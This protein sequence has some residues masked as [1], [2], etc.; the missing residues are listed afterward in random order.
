[1]KG[2]R[3]LFIFMELFF[4]VFQLNAQVLKDNELVIIGGQKF[5]IHQVRTGET[6]YSLSRDFRTE[7]SDIIQFNEG[8]EHGINIGALL[9]IPYN[10][11]F[12]LSEIRSYKK[13]DP[14]A[15]GSYTIESNNETAYSV[16]KKFG[17]SVEEVYAYNPEI[18]RLKKGLTIRIPQWEFKEV[19]TE[20]TS[21][22][23]ETEGVAQKVGMI[24][25]TVVSGETLYG[26]T[27][28]YNV[29]ESEILKYNPDAGTLKAGSKIWI[30]QVSDKSLTTTVVKKSENKGSEL[31]HMVEPGETFW[32]ISRKYGIN[33]NDLMAANPQI[34]ALQAGMKLNIPIKRNRAENIEAVQIPENS[35]DSDQSGNWNND[36]G[37][38]CAK[39]TP[40]IAAAKNYHIAVFLPLFFDS[41]E[42]LNVKAVPLL[43]DS[44]E[45][46]G[47]TA[48]SLV[49]LNE[50]VSPTYKFFGNSENFLQFYEG[51]LLAVDSVQKEGMK[52]KLSVFDTKDNPETVGNIIN[53]G[54]L[55]GVDLIIGP[56]Y[57]N[58][59]KSVASFALE[60]KIPFVSPFTPK[61]SI[62][63]KNPYF[64]QVNPTREYLVEA[65][66][67]M[68][69]NDFSKSN[70]III[71]TSPNFGSAESQMVEK[72]KSVFGKSGGKFQV[73]D[74]K[75]ERAAGLKNILSSDSENVVFIPTSDEG[76][77]S[78]AISNLNNLAKEFPITLV[79]Q[80]NFQQ[81][82]PS[83]E[84]SH[85]HALK[86]H[87]VNPYW[88]DY[89]KVNTI[90]FV[91][92]FRAA[93]GTEPGS[94]GMQGFDVAWYF[95]NAL[96]WYGNNFELCTPFH[97]PELVQGSYMFRKVSTDGGF[98]N[99]GVSVVNYTTD[100]EVNRKY[101]AV[102]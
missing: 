50:P 83:I 2:F 36:A 95:L 26:L 98:M 88:V 80:S 64:F 73:Y 97:Q 20:L 71:K 17:I 11:S 48:D 34:S 90:A 70:F 19:K 4:I 41:N 15:F 12:D 39:L 37:S 69:S 65:T 68:I 46:A 100:F 91:E 61:S 54:E 52:V 6:V 40:A 74:F 99:E 92:K 93:F 21:A 32:G 45:M 29:S 84:I 5:I 62:I 63:N 96:F 23:K 49:E 79:A 101:I 31:I 22:Q 86:M 56:V 72:I 24:E 43:T 7:P 58:V 13:G 57:E 33:E 3:F 9:K 16:S 82:Y 89:S 18:Q 1:M 42:S 14:T 78:V 30:P 55:Q 66:I 25:H 60:N 44:L 27:R 51:I 35:L 76:E 8:I 53:K 85:F 94:Y 59:Q 75:K 102:E 38:G 81:R 47:I 77:L 67:K 10:G 87:Y 28:K